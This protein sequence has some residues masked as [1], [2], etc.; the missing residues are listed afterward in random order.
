MYEE[1]AREGDPQ[2][3]VFVGWMLYEGYGV[4]RDKEV[5]LSWFNERR[6]W[7]LRRE[8]FI[9]VAARFPVA[10][11]Q[12]DCFGFIKRPHRNMVRPCC[13]LDWPIFEGMAL[14]SIARKEFTIWSGRRQPGITSQDASLLS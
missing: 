12:R 11:T 8:H 2:C 9:V 1:L 10:T 3:Q 14:L 13:G 4:P 6:P 7:V 5:A